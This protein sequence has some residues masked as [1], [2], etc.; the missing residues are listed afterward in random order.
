MQLHQH[1]WYCCCRRSIDLFFDFNTLQST[2]V[3]KARRQHS[4][5]S[6][7]RTLPCFSQSITFYWFMQFYSYWNVIFP[8][9]SLSVSVPSDHKNQIKDRCSRTRPEVLTAVTMKMAVFWVV[10]QFQRS[11][12]L[13]MEAVQTSETSVN[14]YQSTRRYDPEDS[15][16]HCCSPRMHSIDGTGM[17][18]TKLIRKL[19]EIIRHQNATM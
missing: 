1:S 19:A 11:I 8:Y 17:L 7:P 9:I 12:V 5:R 18:G 3:Q 16:L 6:A 13:M 2:T 10:P 14:S 4:K 15:H